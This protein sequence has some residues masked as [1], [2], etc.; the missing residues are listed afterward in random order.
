MQQNIMAAFFA[1]LGAALL[2][3]AAGETVHPRLR[4]MQVHGMGHVDAKEDSSGPAALLAMLQIPGSNITEIPSIDILESTLADLT[5]DKK[6]GKV[7]PGME[8]FVATVQK[9]IDTEMIPAIKQGDKD[10]RQTLRNFVAGFKRCSNIRT[11]ASGPIRTMNIVRGSG[12]KNHQAC[13]RVENG[14]YIKKEACKAVV[15]AKRKVKAAACGAFKALHRNPESEANKCHTTPVAEPYGG[16]LTRN[17][18]FFQIKLRAFEKAK[19]LCKQATIAWR[20]EK[21]P[22]DQKIVL[23]KKTRTT[24]TTRQ[25]QLQDITCTLGKKMKDTCDKYDT[26]HDAQAALYRKQKPKLQT[27][28]KDR[29]G[30]FRA[31]KRIE[32]LLKTVEGSA[33]DDEINECKKKTHSTKWLDIVYP[34]I[35]GKISCPIMPPIPGE[36]LF[37]VVEFSKLSK[38]TPPAAVSKCVLSPAGGIIMGVER[39]AKL[40]YKNFCSVENNWLSAANGGSCLI[41]ERNGN[42]VQ[43]NYKKARYTKFRFIMKMDETSTRNGY[44]GGGGF[45]PCNNNNV[46]W[47]SSSPAIQFVDAKKSSDWGYKLTPGWASNPIRSRTPVTC[48]QLMTKYQVWGKD[49]SGIDVSKYTDGKMK[50][51]G[52]MGDGCKPTDFFCTQKRDEIVFGA[53][54]TMRA[55]LGKNVPS[56]PKGPLACGSRKN[57]TGM[58]NPMDRSKDIDRMCQMMGYTRGT[59]LKRRK[60]NFCPG[61]TSTKTGWG[62]NFRVQTSYGSEFRCQGPAAA[63]LYSSKK[64]YKTAEPSKGKSVQWSVTMEYYKGKYSIKKLNIG[65]K[66]FDGYAG[67]IAQCSAR[68]VYAFAPRVVAQP[69]RG[70]VYIKDFRVFQ[71]NSLNTK[72]MKQVVG[73]GVTRDSK[74]ELKQKL[75]NAVKNAYKTV[76][77]FRMAFLNIKN[78]TWARMYEEAAKKKGRL[79]TYAEAKLFIDRRKGVLY[80]NKDYWAAVTNP[81]EKKAKSSTQGR[82]DWIQL[83]NK[84]HKPKLSHS[85]KFGY[86]VWGD[87]SKA[88]R[89]GS[90]TSVLLY[91]TKERQNPLSKAKVALANKASAAKA[92]VALARKNVVKKVVNKAKK[93]KAAVKKVARNIRRSIK[94]FFRRR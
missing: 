68:G 41:S 56:T 32:C 17:R 58:F 20:R 54:G 69:A 18:K 6:A 33:T 16:W 94:K 78:P 46:L 45:A 60:Q 25:T 21:I 75:R 12:S 85:Q 61:V 35:P 66:S 13:R 19:E 71:G 51:L 74:N 67:T 48:K 36:S 24:C 7:T 63:G 79:M 27:Q 47:R 1:A 11:T 57:P 59:I 37:R 44:K 26:C 9:M 81:N 72:K 53:T 89:G 91:V 49:A 15:E 2:G 3:S 42:P 90:T 40:K 34:K 14:Q 43:V 29:K 84:W 38:N 77:I 50:W 83:G 31:L 82:K 62:S 4:T 55:V 5:A 70:K 52:C 65:G 10:A 92:K 64:Y 8:N 88:N 28:E 76:E 39:S 22:C 87:S 30:E 80:A 73:Q 23:Y 93:A 86:P